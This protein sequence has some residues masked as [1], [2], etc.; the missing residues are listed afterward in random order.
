MEIVGR[1]FLAQAAAAIAHRHPDVTMFAAGISSGDGVAVPEFDRE[2]GLLAAAVERCRRAHRRLLYFS[3]SSV[4]MYGTRRASACEDDPVEPCSPYGRHKRAMEMLITGSGTRH[5]ILRLAY[6]V[7][8]GQRAHQFVPSLVDQ[9][10]SGVVQIKRGARRDLIDI[11][12]VVTLVD[13]L[14]GAG[15]GDHVVNVASG[16]GVPVERIVE[17]IEQR[18]GAVT[19]KTFLDVAE[20]PQICIHHL[21]RLVPGVRALNFGPYYYQRVLDRYLRTRVKSRTSSSGS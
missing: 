3:T 19:D 4:G 21:R 14:L 12:D 18:L 10:R 16:T 7:G 1:G 2:A 6:P 11:G 8:A 20:E 5:L 15:N 17:H 9:V 13:S